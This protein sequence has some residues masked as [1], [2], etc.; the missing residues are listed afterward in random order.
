MKKR[1]EELDFVK[2]I[3]IILMVLFHLVFFQ[4]KYPYAKQFVYTFHMPL[5]LVLSGYLGNLKKNIPEFLTTVAGFLIPYLVMDSLYVGMATVLPIREHIDH[6]TVGVILKHIFISPMGP[7]WYL[8]TLAFCMLVYYFVFR[9]IRANKITKI[10]FTALLLYGVTRFVAGVSFTSV[11]YFL[12]GVAIRHL[13]IPF[14]KRF[15]SV[16]A[17]LPLVWL[18][19]YPENLERSQPSG[20]AVAALALSSILACYQYFGT[21]L[22]GFLVY[23]GRNTLTIMVFSPLFTFVTKFL[24][25]WLDFD[26][27][28]LLCAFIS[29]S[30]VL[31]GSLGL[32]RLSDYIGVSRFLYYKSTVYNPWHEAIKLTK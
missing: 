8:H 3:L 26:P 16:W 17:L 15:A 13:Q 30:L 12:I 27:T 5:F 31:A 4:E 11:I 29:V 2:G 19:F 18:A 9:W 24:V 6:P 21:F 7:Y 28:G 32:A 10:I 1:I 25:S 14:D 20:Y 22:R 23:L